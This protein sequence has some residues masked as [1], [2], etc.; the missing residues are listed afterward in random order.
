MHGCMHVNIYIYI[1]S[2]ILCIYKYNIVNK[3]GG[4]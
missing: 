4:P 1:I 2:Y 3:F